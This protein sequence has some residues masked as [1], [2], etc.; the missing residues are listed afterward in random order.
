MAYNDVNNGDVLYEA[1]WDSISNH[2]HTGASLDG[3]TLDLKYGATYIV[4]TGGTVNVDCHYT[5]IGAAVTAISTNGGKIFVKKGSYSENV[6]L[7][8]N[9]IILE[10]EGEKTII[11]GTLT[12]SG[13][14]N[15]I[16]NLFLDKN[17]TDLLYISGDNNVFE[18]VKVDN[19]TLAGANYAVRI[20]GTG[21]RLLGC[22]VTGNSAEL[23]Q[24]GI[25]ITTGA[26]ETKLEGTYSSA[27]RAYVV[28]S[29]RENNIATNCHFVLPSSVSAGQAVQLSGYRNIVDSSLIEITGNGGSQYGV[30]VTGDNCIV[31][32]CIIDFSANAQATTDGLS[33]GTSDARNIIIGNIFNS[34]AGDDASINGDYTKVVGNTFEGTLNI[35]ANANDTVFVGNY[36]GALTDNGTGTWPKRYKSLSISTTAFGPGLPDVNDVNINDHTAT[37]SSGIVQL[38]APVFLPQGAL[39]TAAIVY[40][41]ADTETWKLSRSAYDSGSASVMAS[42]ALDVQDSTISNA[43]IDNS[44]YFYSIYADALDAGEYVRGARI[45][46][47][48]D[49]YNVY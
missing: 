7:S 29:G 34:G 21:N 40:G 19:T 47:T 35:T 38:Q 48:Y 8:N 6:T 20:F 15:L 44:A 42:A 3:N 24:F 43:T 2:D 39:I 10:G 31:S 16:R 23:N 37:V 22:H 1:D 41:N 46:Y 36:I 30:Q 12:V 18:N 26:S 17:V 45:S 11:V 9:E 27:Y 28:G 49:P 4:K 5:T 32:N 14:N 33:V 25:F 13:N